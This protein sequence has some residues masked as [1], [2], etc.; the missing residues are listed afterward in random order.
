MK[1]RPPMAP[2]YAE[3]FL[4]TLLGSM[5]VAGAI[6]FCAFVQGRLPR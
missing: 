5:L 2:R 1:A 3:A 6:A 4:W